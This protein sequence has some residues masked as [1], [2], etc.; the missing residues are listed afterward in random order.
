[1]ASVGNAL[2]KKSDLKLVCDGAV[3]RLRIL[4]DNANAIANGYVTDEAGRKG[5][6]LN[7]ITID[8]LFRLRK[9]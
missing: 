3:S 8:T 5:N 4:I 6:A 9:A 7:Q 2:D 1:M